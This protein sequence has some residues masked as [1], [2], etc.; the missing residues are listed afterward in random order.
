MN[1]LER[2]LKDCDELEVICLIHENKCVSTLQTG[3][4]FKQDFAKRNGMFSK[5]DIHYR[6]LSKTTKKRE[7]L[8]SYGYLNVIVDDWKSAY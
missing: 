4:E 3:K 2:Y 5:L 8:F 6:G 1:A 7:Y